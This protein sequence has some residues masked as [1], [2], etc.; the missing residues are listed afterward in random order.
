MRGGVGPGLGGA[1]GPCCTFSPIP[2][3]AKWLLSVEMLAGRLE[4]L[5]LVVPL[6]RTFWRS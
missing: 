1:I 6:T 5:V 2:D 4:I 3:A